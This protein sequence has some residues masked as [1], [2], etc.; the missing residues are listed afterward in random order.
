MIYKLILCLV[1]F[2]AP[3]SIDAQK[4]RSSYYKFTKSNIILTNGDTIKGSIKFKR[5]VYPNNFQF[6]SVETGKMVD[7]T[8]ADVKYI[9]IYR[10]RRKENKYR[11]FELIPVAGHSK[12]IVIK[13]EIEGRKADLYKFTKSQQA[14]F[15]PNSTHRIVKD[16]FFVFKKRSKEAIEVKKKIF[17]K[18]RLKALAAI[19][20]D[21]PELS[22]KIKAGDFE[23]NNIFEKAS[24]M[25][26][27]MQYYNYKCD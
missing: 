14:M 3:S 11:T 1:F 27:I 15:P 13:K 20:E 17:R 16:Y 5:S 7:I 22:R 12:P 9:H 4:I 25:Q 8:P 10:S 23:G 18:A 26:R 21:C 6:K 2:L 24:W 19:F